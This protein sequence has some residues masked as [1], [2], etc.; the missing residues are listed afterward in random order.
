[1]DWKSILTLV[2]VIALWV[3]LMRFVLPKAGVDT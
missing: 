2:V 3:F 1:M